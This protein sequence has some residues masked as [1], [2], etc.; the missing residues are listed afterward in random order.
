MESSLKN[1]LN[2][3]KTQIAITGW[4]ILIYRSKS[5]SKSASSEANPQWV[6]LTKWTVIHS[7]LNLF[8]S[9]KSQGHTC[10]FRCMLDSTRNSISET[11]HSNLFLA[12]H[13]SDAAAVWLSKTTAPF[14]N[15]AFR[16]WH[17]LAE[18][19]WLR[20]ARLLAGLLAR[21][22]ARLFARLPAIRYSQGY[23]LGYSLG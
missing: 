20:Q 7:I 3:T 4:L 15:S 1:L 5:A 10:H 16:V 21:L 17:G 13:Q 23:S 11:C 22:L 2:W 18:Q 19:Q 12:F 6:L 9:T 14:G 8:S